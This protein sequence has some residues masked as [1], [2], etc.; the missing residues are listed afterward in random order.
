VLTEIVVLIGVAI[1]ASLARE[2]YG[3]KGMFVLP[4]NTDKGYA[5]GSFGAIFTALFAIIFNLGLILALAPEAFTY[6][7][8]ISL[9]LSWGI[10]SPDIFANALSRINGSDS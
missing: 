8:A 7:I 4:H 5:L 2:Y 1:F 9:G 6:A 3:N 10:A